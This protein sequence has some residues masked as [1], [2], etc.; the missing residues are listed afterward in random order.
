M[1]TPYVRCVCV[2][3]LE[4]EVVVYV[5]DCYRIVVDEEDVINVA[6]VSVVVCCC[7]SVCGSAKPDGVASRL[8]TG[9][10]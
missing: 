3:E 2:H 7:A 4:E 5:H 10:S 1:T 9:S 6:F 8:H